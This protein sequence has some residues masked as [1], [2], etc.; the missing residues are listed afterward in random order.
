[1]GRFDIK[2][3]ELLS[4]MAT[5]TS[6][7]TEEMTPA[8]KAIKLL[9]PTLL[10]HLRKADEATIAK[11]SKMF[12]DGM[13]WVA[14]G[15]EIPSD[16]DAEPASNVERDSIE[17]ISAGTDNG[18]VGVGEVDSGGV[19]DSPI[20]DGLSTVEDSGSGHETEVQG[21][22]DGSWPSGGEIVQEMGSR[23]STRKLDASAVKL[24]S[25]EEPA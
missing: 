10:K 24:R 25:V 23:R 16:N 14:T 18:S 8:I 6:D 12:A 3:R 9:M 15:K 17:E 4:G 11:F 21:G 7:G 22:V 5:V 13:Y 19:S 20:F 1:M 2:M